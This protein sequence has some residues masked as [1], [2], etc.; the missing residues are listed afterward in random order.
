MLTSELEVG[1]A[2]MLRSG[3]V[4]K[5]LAIVGESKAN[6][7]LQM[8]GGGGRKR[9]VTADAIIR[10][11]YPAAVPSRS[12]RHV[13]FPSPPEDLGEEAVGPAVTWTQQINVLDLPDF[14]GRTVQFNSPIGTATAAA[15]NDNDVSDNYRAVVANSW[16]RPPYGGESGTCSCPVCRHYRAR[17]RTERVEPPQVPSQR[18]VFTTQPVVSYEDY[19]EAMRSPPSTPF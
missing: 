13:M 12:E 9:M 6:V 7:Q 11:A 8:C 17:V 2:Y 1:M 18:P 15:E 5:M 14:P 4:G 10:V 3:H 16:P 19:I